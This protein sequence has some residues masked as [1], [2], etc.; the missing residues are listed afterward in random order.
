MLVGKVL[1][2]AD[3]E[4]CRVVLPR[5]AMEANLPEVVEAGILDVVSIPSPLPTTPSRFALSALPCRALPL[6][7]LVFT[8]PRLCLASSLRCP[9]LGL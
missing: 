8:L 9:C 2:R 6:S 3:V 5:M 1:S 4:H 7:C